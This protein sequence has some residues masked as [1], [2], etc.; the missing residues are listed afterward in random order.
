M[1]NEDFGSGGY[2]L[3]FAL[4]GVEYECMTAS[5]ENDLQAQIAKE[6]LEELDC[7]V[8]VYVDDNWNHD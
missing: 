6:Q 3:R 2:Q 5:L 4:E 8:K 1:P 7:V